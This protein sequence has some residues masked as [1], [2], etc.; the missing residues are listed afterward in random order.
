MYENNIYSAYNNVFFTAGI[1]SENE[2][3]N[4]FIRLNSILKNY[5][6]SINPVFNDPSNNIT[7]E[8]MYP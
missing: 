4:N 2:N 6:V 7:N 5:D 8:C 1:L 3:D